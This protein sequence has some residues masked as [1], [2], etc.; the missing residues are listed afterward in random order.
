MLRPLLFVI[1]PLALFAQ[2][3]AAAPA[4][5]AAPAP[6]AAEPVEQVIATPEPGRFKTL[7]QPF[8]TDRAALS[9]DGKYLAYSIRENDV[10]SVAVIEIDHPEK[11]KAYV[12]VVDDESA[13][14]MLAE[15]QA[16]K[17]PGRINWMQW[18]TPTRLV[19]ETNAV[20][21]GDGLG[22]QSY[23]GVVLG[24]D[25]DGSNAKVLATAKDVGELRDTS[26]GGQFSV[27][28]RNGSTFD[29]H[30]HTPDQPTPTTEP[31]DPY[32]I[33]TENTR[34]WNQP[35][36]S[37]DTAA[38][39]NTNSYQPRSPHVFDFD[40]QHPGGVTL[41]VTGPA[42]ES[43]SRSMG[44]MSLDTTTGKV[45]DLVDDALLNSDTALVDRQGHV[46][47]RLPRLS[48]MKPPFNYDYNAPKA[49]G[50]PQPL[51]KQP[52]LA[53]FTV[54]PDNYFGA[55]SI[56]L[57]FDENPNI[58]YYAS[59]LG[60]DTYG[61]Y[62][63][64]LAS[65]KPGA[66]KMENPVFDL[67]GPPLDGFPAP[68]TLVFNR[69]DR[70]LIGIRFTHSVRS[71]AWLRPEWKGLQAE[72]EKT[73]P[74][75]SVEILDWD[76]AGSRF[77]FST[78]GPA[79]PG[80][81][82]IYDRAKGRLSE[83]VRRAPW[84]DAKHAHTTLP[85]A[86]NP[87]DGGP[88]VSGLVTVPQQPRLKPIPMI[89]VCP[90]HPWDRVSSDFQSEVQAL[91]DMG[92]VVVQLNGRGAWGMGLK[93][94]ESLKTGYDLVQVE[95]IAN[96]IGLLGKIF[97]VNLKRVAIMGR[98]HGGF[99]AMRAV[100]EHPELFRCAIAINSPVN[101]GEWL[102]QQHW[103]EDDVQPQLT[104]AWLGDAA[105][106]KAA[107]LTSAPEKLT[108]PVLML[109]YPGPDGAPR[110]LSYVSA[111]NFARAVNNHGGNVDFEGLSMDYMRGLP[112]AHAAAFDQM[113][114]FL[115]THVYDFKV[116]LE[117]LQ[118]VK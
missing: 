81:F 79:D 74:G 7:F 62:T 117:E 29:S 96:S 107:P 43:G 67:V 42:R 51:D 10:V 31:A 24:F 19:V 23:P 84:L 37:V 104:K 73:F 34:P 1:C 9:P 32:A 48:T 86:Y 40:P 30:I 39:Q 78:E 108:K 28:R 11:M 36:D 85:F 33:A 61:I 100:Q 5:T 12:K 70:Q 55:R 64:D 80:A 3:A 35:E 14:P 16:E 20:I 82:Y 59:N 8:R 52:G 69:Y 26:G 83:F 60:R 65:G 56:P 15:N 103:T 66:I 76:Q 92:F 50:R 87:P 99:I 6:A 4:V 46:R 113:E 45:K 109:N 115:N 58:L 72:L 2:S 88:R 27:A 13:T 53:G 95:D 112:G 17:T 91:A 105:R 57:G 22:W 71:T 68:D 118:V 98:G 75:R 102:A 90:D 54:S 114:A 21:A 101:L 110:L 41:F 93:Q 18:V 77:L 94:R 111:Q 44:L 47:L 63:F 38:P 49:L 89:L 116:K 106:L 25:A 97:S